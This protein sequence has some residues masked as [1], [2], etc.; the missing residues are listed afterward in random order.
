M[1]KAI[2]ILFLL[3]PFLALAQDTGKKKAYFFYGEQCPHCHKVDDYFQANGIYDKYEIS[4]LEVSANPFNGKLFLEFGKAFGMS[5]WGG[6]PA[7]VFGDKYIVGD[8]PI[9]DNFV[10]EIDAA[11]N[12]N[13]LP[14]PDK[15]SNSSVENS[16]QGAQ[17]A[18]VSENNNPVPEE[19]TQTGNKNKYFPVVLFVLVL[20]GGGA[21]FFINRKPKE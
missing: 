18:P 4:K 10:K 11:E 19:K 20:V 1:K 12:A 9:I 5:D 14:N 16:D 2:T 8:Q 21:I 13:E 17:A 3:I 6:V 7:V 15:I